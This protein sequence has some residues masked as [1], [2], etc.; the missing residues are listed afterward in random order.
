MCWLHAL[1][2]RP[3]R[4]ADIGAAAITPL[5]HLLSTIGQYLVPVVFL[6]GAAISGLG[7]WKRQRLYASASGEP[8]NVAL[9]EM[10]WRDFELLIGE[11]FRR[12]GYEVQEQGGSAPDGGVDLV[13]RKHGK[14]YLVQ[15]KHWKAWKVGVKVVRELYGVMA[16]E[17]ADGGFVVTSGVFSKEARNF[18]ADKHIVLMD[19]EQL[20]DFLDGKPPAAQ[21]GAPPTSRA[22]RITRTPPVAHATFRAGH[23]RHRPTAARVLCP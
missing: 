12:Q 3:R 7:R 14:R 22:A 8:G 17:N 2:L 19:G 13:L 6:A 21:V 20:R 11:A 15:C 10:S 23:T 9:R 1:R 5:I 18:A 16:A 4:P